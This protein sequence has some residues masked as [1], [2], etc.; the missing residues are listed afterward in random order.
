MSNK[1]HQ[2]SRLIAYLD[3]MRKRKVEFMSKC[4]FCDEKS[5]GIE[6][7][8]HRLYPVCPNHLKPRINTLLE[9][10]TTFEE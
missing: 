1:W 3:E 7:I 6:A 10:Q 2:D 4:Y 8:E 9:S 5:E